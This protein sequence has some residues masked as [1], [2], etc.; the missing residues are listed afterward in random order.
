MLN[1]SPS[2]DGS[3]RARDLL[4]L[5]KK[6]FSIVLCIVFTLHALFIFSLA[7]LKKQ[8]HRRASPR[9]LP[10]PRDEPDPDVLRACREAPRGARE[11]ARRVAPQEC[12]ASL[13]SGYFH[14]LFECESVSKRQT[15][16]LEAEQE[17]LQKS[18]CLTVSPRSSVFFPHR[19]LAFPP[20][21]S[22]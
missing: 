5:E 21:S 20:P 15:F 9:G 6:T 11:A 4:V 10:I 13:S 7:R 16:F 12:L 2:T 18:S 17:S 14:R 22:G 8:G 1:E 3:R 19:L